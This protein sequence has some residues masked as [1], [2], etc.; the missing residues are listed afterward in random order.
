MGTENVWDE[1][2]RAYRTSAPHAGG[3]DLDLL[4][5]WTGAGA[6]KSAL[7]VGTGGGH[8]AKRLEQAGF[9][10]TTCDPASRMQPDVICRAEE[11]PFPVASF[12]LVATRLATHHF[13]D[14]GAALAEMARVAG[15]S[16][17]IEDL[18]FVDERVEEAEK[19]RDDSHVRALSLDEWRELCAA[20]GITV[21]QTEVMDRQISFQA[22]LDRCGCEG[23]AAERARELVSHRLDGDNYTSSVFLLKGVK[24]S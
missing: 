11:L 1:R 8:L 14:L 18:L 3:P 16:V 4:V 5:E 12:D 22:W 15:E 6:G 17:V 19:L 20:R 10:V 13:E 24:T 23:E 21:E 7:D 2:V 9:A